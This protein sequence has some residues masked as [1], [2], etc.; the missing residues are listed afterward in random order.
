[1]EAVRLGMPKGRRDHHHQDI[2]VKMTYR[3]H[4]SISTHNWAEPDAQYVTMNCQTY[5]VEFS[6]TKEGYHNMIP[7]PHNSGHDC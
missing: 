2:Q 3:I 4:Y 5:E 7:L 1:M 6:V